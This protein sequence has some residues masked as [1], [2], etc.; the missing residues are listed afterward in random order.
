MEVDIEQVAQFCKDNF[1]GLIAGLVALWIIS[2]M[3]RKSR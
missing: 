3:V 2:L 1:V